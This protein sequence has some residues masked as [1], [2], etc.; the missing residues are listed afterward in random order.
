MNSLEK[1]DDK[2]SG[3]DTQLASRNHSWAQAETPRFN[4]RKEIK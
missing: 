2:F 4:F 3:S 1:K